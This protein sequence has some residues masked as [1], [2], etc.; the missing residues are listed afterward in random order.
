MSDDLKPE[1]PADED[2][3]TQYP[4]ADQQEG[5]HLM[6]NQAGER[7]KDKGFSEEQIFEW[8]TAYMAEEDA[9]TVDGLV[10]Y[11]RAKESS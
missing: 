9:G 5:V 10:D 4:D 2:I 1:N 8:A 6:A 7:L 11:I 3:S